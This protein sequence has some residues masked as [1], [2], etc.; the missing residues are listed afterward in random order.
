MQDGPKRGA[1]DAGRAMAPL[2]RKYLNDEGVNASY[3]SADSA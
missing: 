3:A 1:R 2:P